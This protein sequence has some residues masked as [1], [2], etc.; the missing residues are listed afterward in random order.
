MGGQ[1]GSPYVGVFLTKD[2]A[3]VKSYLNRA[4]IK[5]LEEYLNYIRVF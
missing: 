2:T 5:A 1:Q 4:D 3:V